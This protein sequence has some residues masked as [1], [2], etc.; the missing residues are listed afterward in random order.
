MPG[1][2]Y[3]QI[4]LFLVFMSL[5]TIKTAIIE[6]EKKSLCLRKQIGAVV[7]KNGK[8]IGTGHNGNSVN[9][10]PCSV[11]GCAKDYFKFRPG[12]RN[13]LCTGI[14]A[15]QRAMIDALKKGHDL[16][17]T[18]LYSTYSPCVSCSRYMIEF[19][20]KKVYYKKEYNDAFARQVQKLGKIE[21]EKII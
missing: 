3:K 19:G 4:H 2:L 5:N 8:I 6:E 11:I 14:C 16:K 12:L 21:R 9:I 20:I 10:P 13:E 17:D 15:E 18:E 1:N 7:V